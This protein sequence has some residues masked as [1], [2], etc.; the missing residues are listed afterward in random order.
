MLRKGG[1]FLRNKGSLR[2]WG[3]LEGLVGMGEGGFILGKEDPGGMGD[4]RGGGGG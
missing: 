4:M 3:K 2:G 1:K